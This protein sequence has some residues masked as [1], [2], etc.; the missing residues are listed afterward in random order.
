MFCSSGI[1][2]IFIYLIAYQKLIK[3]LN[4]QMCELFKYNWISFN[5]TI[6]DALSQ[7]QLDSKVDTVVD[8]VKKGT[9]RYV[10]LKWTPTN[11]LVVDKTGGPGNF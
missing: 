6:F 10:T 7:A 8:D 2:F 9:K 11:I 5:D 4:Q 3:I 1:L